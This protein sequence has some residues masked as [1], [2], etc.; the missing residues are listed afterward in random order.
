MKMIATSSNVC[1]FVL[2]TLKMLAIGQLIPVVSSFAF[3]VGS[4][5]GMTTAPLCRKTLP[6]NNCASSSS[7][8]AS[9]DE[10]VSAP[11]KKESTPICDLQTFLKLCGLVKSG[12]E[13]KHAI[14]SDQCYLNGEVE[15]RRAKK[16]FSGDEVSFVSTNDVLITKDVSDEVQKKGYVYK[17]KEKKVKPS[18]RVIDAYGTLE[19]G[20]RHRSEEW[21]AERKLKKADRKREKAEQRTADQKN[22]EQKTNDEK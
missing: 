19:F 1:V 3:S 7:L 9:S 4:S 22:A 16:L 10:K 14:Q 15:T 18:A 20:G 17:K 6:Y 2:F 12:A 11:Q 8:F 21:R 13:A 5:N